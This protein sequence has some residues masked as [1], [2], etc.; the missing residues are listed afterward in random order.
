[1]SRKNDKRVR[2]VDAADELIYQQTFN[3]TTLADIA[4]RADVPL[5]NVYYYFKTKDEIL[6]AVVQK[7]E[8]ELETLF[9]TW[10]Q[11]PNVKDRLRSY[12]AQSIQGSDTVARF[13]CTLGSLCQELGKHGGEIALMGAALM[14]KSFSWVEAQFKG[15][16][17][18]DKS[19]TLAEY[20]I[21]NIQ[22]ASLVTLTF[23]D[24][25]FLQKQSKNLELWLETA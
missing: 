11:L 14:R 4:L 23:K 16:G 8:A 25:N 2:L 15:L 9:A 6:K 19:G 17:K 1:M 24:P 12:I 3:S 7:R 22:G 13:G 18:G 20:L 5:G 21:A 10:D